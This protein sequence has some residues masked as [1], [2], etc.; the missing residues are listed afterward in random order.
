VCVCQDIVLGFVALEN[1]TDTYLLLARLGAQKLVLDRIKM[2]NELREAQV[3]PNCQRRPATTAE[4][5][6]YV[7]RGLKVYLST[8]VP[9]SKPL[10]QVWFDFAPYYPG[11]G[12]LTHAVFS[13]WHRHFRAARALLTKGPVTILR[14]AHRSI[15]I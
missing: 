7:E 1:E 9:Q 15:C 8:V 13:F 6:A 5:T 4:L 3:F 11:H 14:Y 12:L 2:N 10:P